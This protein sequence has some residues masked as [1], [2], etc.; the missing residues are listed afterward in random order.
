MLQMDG[1]IVQ[2]FIKTLVCNNY[3]D[4]TRHLELKK[5]VGTIN[6]KKFVQIHL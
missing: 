2:V 5:L 6:S 3:T 1:L 4:V